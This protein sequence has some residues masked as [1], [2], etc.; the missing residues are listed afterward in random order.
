MSYFFDDQRVFKTKVVEDIS[1]YTG[2]RER[3]VIELHRL[4]DDDD[5]YSKNMLNIIQSLIITPS[6][7]SLLWD[8]VNL[9]LEVASAESLIRYKEEFKEESDRH[10]LYKMENLYSWEVKCKHAVLEVQNRLSEYL[11]EEIGVSDAIKA[12]KENM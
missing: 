3:S 1:K 12:L 6:G 5:S 11:D 8:L 2:L 10:G 9:R 7:H 4:A